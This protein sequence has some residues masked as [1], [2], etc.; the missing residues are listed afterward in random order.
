MLFSIINRRLYWI[1]KDGESSQ[2]Q[3]SLFDGSGLQDITT[4]TCQGDLSLISVDLD[5]QRVYV[6]D[7]TSKRLCD[8]DVERGLTREVLAAQQD[9]QFIAVINV[10]TKCKSQTRVTLLYSDLHSW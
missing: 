2:V 8:I 10:S 1:Y 4:Y 7:K 3:S 6:F 9:M 5:S